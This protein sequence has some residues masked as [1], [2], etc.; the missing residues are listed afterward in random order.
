MASTRYMSHYVLMCCSH[1]SNEI[2]L[3]SWRLSV[4][5]IIYIYIYIYTYIYIVYVRV[6][7][8]C[9]CAVAMVVATF[10]HNVPY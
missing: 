2:S 8:V 5:S 3:L 6:L 10:A 4:T 1:V 7:C 9:V